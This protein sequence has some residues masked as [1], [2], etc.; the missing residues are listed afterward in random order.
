[1]RCRASAI[2]ALLA[3]PK[4]CEYGVCWKA[5]THSG[6]GGGVIGSG[7]DSAGDR[8]ECVREA[9]RLNAGVEILGSIAVRRAVLGL[10]E[11]SVSMEGLREDSPEVLREFV[12]RSKK[13]PLKPPDLLASGLTAGGVLTRF[14]SDGKKFKAPWPV[15]EAL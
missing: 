4:R 1:M 8:V 5:V 12:L 2:S 15:N 10:G 11:S 14:I 3:S 13:K 9:E 7:V 6:S